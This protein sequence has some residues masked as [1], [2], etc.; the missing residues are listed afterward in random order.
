MAWFDKLMRFLYKFNAPKQDWQHM[1]WSLWLYALGWVI[2]GMNMWWIG[3]LGGVFYELVQFFFA[4]KMQLRLLDRVRD[5]WGH[6]ITATFLLPPPVWVIVGGLLWY[7]AL[8]GQRKA[9]GETSTG[10]SEVLVD[11][12]GHN[13]AP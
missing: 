3:P 4:D 8:W 6:S 9:V 12:A 2:F 7:L 10:W 11:D 1:C 13:S 5:V